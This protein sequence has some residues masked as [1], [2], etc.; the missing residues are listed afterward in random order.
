[1]MYLAMK[2]W[3]L[4]ISLIAGSV[5]GCSG[6]AKTDNSLPAGHTVDTRKVVDFSL[7]R[8]GGERVSL[9]SLRGQLVLITFFTTWSLRSQAEAPQFIQ[10][11][12]RLGP[13]G[14]KILGILLDIKTNL[15]MIRTYIEHV[16]FRF[17]VLLAGPEELLGALGTTQKVPRTVLLDR[18][19]HIV[20]DHRGQTNFPQLEAQILKRLKAR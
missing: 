11:Y 3:V 19:G 20:L 5:L 9:V 7:P 18:R 15:T 12:D 14:L 6:K 10:L 2:R 4:L 8:I 13:R 16:G 1:M 17:D